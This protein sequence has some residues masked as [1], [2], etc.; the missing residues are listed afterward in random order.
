M[1]NEEYYDGSYLGA[2]NCAYELFSEA[3]LKNRGKQLEADDP[4]E[5]NWKKYAL[6]FDIIYYI[7]ENGMFNWRE[8]NS[9][10]R[11]G[12]KFTQLQTQNALMFAGPIRGGKEN[13]LIAEMKFVLPWES[14]IM[15]GKELTAYY[16]REAE[17]S[18]KAKIAE[19]Q[20][21][22]QEQQDSHRQGSAWSAAGLCYHCG[23]EMGG[24]FK[25]RCKVCGKDIYGKVR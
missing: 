15:A 9:K 17:E 8:H 22:V 25:K 24:L 11:P 2:A 3:Y 18:A 19:M 21:Q 4:F 16:I 12:L 23:G 1:P 20:A 6:A 14:G 10:I 5:P 7:Y 13:S